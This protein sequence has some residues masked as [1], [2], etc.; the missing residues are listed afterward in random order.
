MIPNRVF[1]EEAKHLESVPTLS[2]EPIRPKT[3]AIRKTNV[4][5]LMS[6]ACKAQPQRDWLTE[7]V[8]VVHYLQN[9]YEVPKGTYFPGRMARIEADAQTGRVGF[10]DAKT[11]EL[12]AKHDISYGHLDKPSSRQ[13]PPDF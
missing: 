4:V 9:R 12:L 10:Y 5:Q 6:Q 3:A 11:D 1:I 7:G 2:S 8:P 13:I